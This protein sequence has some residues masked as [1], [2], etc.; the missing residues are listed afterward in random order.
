[1][2]K[3]VFTSES[4]TEGH[5]DKV[6]DRISDSVLDAMLAQDKFS[7]VACE[8]CC[9]TGLVLVVGEIT[10]NAKNVDVEKI[11]RDAIADIGYTKKEYGFDNKTCEVIVRL[12][13]QSSDIALG[14]DNS[15]EEKNGGDQYDQI[16][17]G[18]QG[19]VFGCATN[20]TPNYMPMPIYLAHKLTRQLTK[21]RKDGT[22][23]YLRPDGKAQVT[24]EYIDE[25]P[26]HINAVVVSTQHNPDVDIEQLRSDIK[27]YVIGV[28][29][30]KELL[31][32]NTKYYINPTGRFVI[33][34]PAGDS[35]V[36]GRKIIVDTYGGYCTH[37]GGAFSGK[38]PTKVDRSA[39]YMAR[40]ICKNLV[41]SGLVDRCQLDISYAIGVAHPVSIQLNTFGTGKTSDETLNKIIAKVFDMRPSAI[42]EKLNLRDV[43]YVDTCNYGHFGKEEMPW[44]KTNK[45]E[46]ILKEYELIK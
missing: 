29:L 9:S 41:A 12:D 6:C 43:K 22:L 21:V 44:E 26:A 35:G 36:T 1:M 30:P 10:S 8:T 45:V 25:K 5:P 23:D 28:A 37:G 38:D 4:V 31:D 24:V 40:Y 18:D 33:G 46:D 3:R 14:V 11:V 39:C 2:N 32:E 7:R 34:G 15:V 42:I 13:K 20:E 27:K 19:M 16:G 17:A